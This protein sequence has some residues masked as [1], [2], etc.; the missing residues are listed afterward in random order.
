MKV[1]EAPYEND[2]RPLYSS[3][4]E[5]PEASE[6]EGLSID[7]ILKLCEKMAETED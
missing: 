5:M 1:N 2:S 4:D 3:R 6:Y 7:D